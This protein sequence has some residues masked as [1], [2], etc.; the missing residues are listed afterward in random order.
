MAKQESGQEKRRWYQTF[1]D[2]YTVV[3]RSYKWAPA[4]LIALPVLIA[5]LFITYAI[6]NSSW[7]FPMITMVLLSITADMALLTLLL[8]PA[9]Y[10]QIDG[11]VGAAYAAISQI[12]KGWVY[13]DEPVGINR[14]QDMV[15]ELVGR[16]GVVLVSEGPSNRVRPML[17]NERKRIQRA[18]SNVPITFIEAG[19][20]KD[21]V[22]IKKLQRKL[23]SLKKVLTKQEVPVVASRLKA[24]GSRAPGVPKGID[25]YNTRAGRK[26]M[27]Q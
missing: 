22:P 4:A 19:N 7:I 24:L 20:E 5:G 27:W 15:W 11:R 13:S 6:I 10:Q 16:P 2:S 23:K 3:K 26:A 8:R 12:R 18:V 1:T 25:P 9:M 17:N 14:H 21:Q